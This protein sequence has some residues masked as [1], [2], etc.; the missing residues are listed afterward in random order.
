[1]CSPHGVSLSDPVYGD[2]AS[3]LTQ[4]GHEAIYHVHSFASFQLRVKKALADQ[5]PRRPPPTTGWPISLPTLGTPNL[6]AKPLSTATRA[7]EHDDH[8]RWT[9]SNSDDYTENSQNLN[10]TMTYREPLPED[11]PPDEAEEITSPHLVYRL[12]RNIPP[13]HNDF[14][15]QRA[16]NPLHSS[17]FLSAGRAACPCSPTSATQKGKPDDATSET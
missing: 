3:N 16:E 1:M 14:R 10:K 17:T 11:C 2:S 7:L 12:V 13:I 15:S 5:R 9:E 4:A 8:N 6:P